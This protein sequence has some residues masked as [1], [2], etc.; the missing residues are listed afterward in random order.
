[1]A[2]PAIKLVENRRD[3]AICETTPRYDV[4]LNGVKFDQLYFN[5]RGYVGRLPFPGGGSLW[6]GECSLTSI[7]KEV[8]KLNREWAAHKET[9]TA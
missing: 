3:M 4:M 6:V 8:S 7:R 9:A 5:C 1:M 2:Q